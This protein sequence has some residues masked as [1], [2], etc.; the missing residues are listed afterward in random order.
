MRFSAGLSQTLKALIPQSA[1][2]SL[3]NL[4]RF[5]VYT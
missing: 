1:A 2:C 5:G 3:A 4:H